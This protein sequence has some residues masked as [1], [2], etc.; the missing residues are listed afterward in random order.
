MIEL[1]ISHLKYNVVV[2]WVGA[3]KEVNLL[4][5]DENTETVFT[6]KAQLFYSNKPARKQGEISI[7][8]SNRPTL[9]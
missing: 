5:G 2:G 6:A 8:I 9:G 1:T 7:F 4:T 3:A